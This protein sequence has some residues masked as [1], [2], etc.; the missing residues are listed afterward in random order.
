MPIRVELF[1]DLVVLAPGVVN[2]RGDSFGA[3]QCAFDGLTRHLV[4]ACRLGQLHPELGEPV[5]RSEQR[6]A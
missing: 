5:R 4:P 3:Q 1:G 6:F 2:L